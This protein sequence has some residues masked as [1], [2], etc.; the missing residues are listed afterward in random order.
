MRQRIG[1]APAAPNREGPARDDLLTRTPP[2]MTSVS[3]PIIHEAFEV[4]ARTTPWRPAVSWNGRVTTYGELNAA[5]NRLAR[6]LAASGVRLDDRVGVVLPRSDD[7]IVAVLGALKSGGAY[8][9]MD[10]AWPRARLER[11][12]ADAALAA[13]VTR[14]SL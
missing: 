7:W 6:R 10:V 4:W 3:S 13:V 11:A 12:A 8:A 14:R 1:A 2:V 5:A 9:P